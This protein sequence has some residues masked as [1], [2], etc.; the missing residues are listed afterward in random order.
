M[1]QSIAISIPEPIT[2]PCN[3]ATIGLSRDRNVAPD[4][5]LP[6]HLLAMTLEG[7]V[8]NSVRS[9]PGAEGP[10]PSPRSRM[11]RTSG[12]YARLQRLAH[13]VPHLDVV[14]IQHAR[15]VRAISA[16]SRPCL[17]I[18]SQKPRSRA[19]VRSVL[20]RYR[21]NKNGGEGAKPS[22]RPDNYNDDLALA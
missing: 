5:P 1:S 13:I 11:Q 22:K 7:A 2:N 14:G 4:V 6:A 10:V 18:W 21:V 3:A 16:T 8:P 15:P 20:H 12:S 17:A 19:S 9:A